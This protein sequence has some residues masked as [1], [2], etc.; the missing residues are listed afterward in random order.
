MFVEAMRKVLKTLLETHTY[1]FAGE[2]RRQR[3][4]GPIGME[5]T[6]VVAQIFMV[7]WDREFTNKLEL[8]NMKLKMHQRYVDDTN[9]ATK[10]T[11][12]GARY[13][14]TDVMVTEGSTEE[15]E[16]VPDDERTLKF[17]Q[18][19]ANSI[20][21]SIRM[22]IDY[23]SRYMDGKVPMLNIKTWI[24]EIEGRRFVLY[25]HYEKEMATKAVIHASSAVPFRMKRTVC[26]Q[27]ML[28]IMLHC[29]RRL[30]WET[31]KEHLNNYMRKL[32]FSG[33]DKTFRYTVAKSAINA[34]EAIRQARYIHP[35][36]SPVC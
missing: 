28:R 2:L 12:I 25:E 13:N 29:S 32:Q 4:G 20:H 33:Y 5:L 11:E 3:N 22:T 18:S 35:S 34:Y 8:I 7:W 19:V 17:L 27:D 1:N 26:T 16:G 23:A 36:L 6:G 10:R 14:G 9:L 31:V 21:P 15:D 24:E 30:T